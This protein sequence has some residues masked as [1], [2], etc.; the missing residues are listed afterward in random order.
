M[1]LFDRFRKKKVEAVSNEMLEPIY[2]E[3]G[4]GLS[5]E[6]S[7][8]VLREEIKSLFPETG[9]WYSSCFKRPNEV[10]KMYLPCHLRDN[11]WLTKYFQQ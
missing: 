6:D 7:F 1:G 3:V 11:S 5:R 8:V 2:E 4:K 10:S 9:I